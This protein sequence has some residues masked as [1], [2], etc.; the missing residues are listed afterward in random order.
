MALWEFNTSCLSRSPCSDTNKQGQTNISVTAQPTNRITLNIK[1]NAEVILESKKQFRQDFALSQEF[2]QI[3]H[4]ALR[5]QARNQAFFPFFFG[6]GT[7]E[8]PNYPLSYTTS[9]AVRP[10]ELKHKGKWYKSAE[11]Q[12]WKMVTANWLH[13]PLGFETA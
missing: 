13:A 3:V 2:Q 12:V 8:L 1:K 11:S 7:D 5:P 9:V 10:N 6:Q 4:P